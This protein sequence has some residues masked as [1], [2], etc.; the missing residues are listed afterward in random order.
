M[1]LLRNLM[2]EGHYRNF[3]RSGESQGG[4]C[5]VDILGFKPLGLVIVL[6]KTMQRLVEVVAT[7]RALNG[8]GRIPS[9]IVRVC[10]AKAFPV[11]LR[12]WRLQSADH[13]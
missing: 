4:E 9:S 8:Y 12:D 13:P 7:D 3:A 1:Q 11:P 6:E 2:L 5:I 10:Q